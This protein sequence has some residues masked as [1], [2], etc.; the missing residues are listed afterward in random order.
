MTSAEAT[1]LDL[2]TENWAAGV[3]HPSSGVLAGTG[4]RKRRELPGADEYEIDLGRH[5]IPSD[6]VRRT[7]QIAAALQLP[8]DQIA[9]EED[10]SLER[11]VSELATETFTARLVVGRRRLMQEIQTHPG[12]GALAADGPDLRVAIGF[13]M[14]GQ[15]ARWMLRSRRGAVNGSIFGAP[16]AGGTNL[17]L[18]LLAATRSRA[19][20]D[21]CAID[22]GDYAGA[23]REAAQTA[24]SIAEAIDLLADLTSTATAPGNG[25]HHL[26]LID[27]LSRLLASTSRA[28]DLLLR[29]LQVAQSTGI[30]V[31]MRVDSPDLASFGGDRTLRSA[32]WRGNFVA[33]RSAVRWPLIFRD[34]SLPTDPTELPEDLPGV[35]YLRGRNA[36]FRGYQL[37]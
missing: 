9:V 34:P 7:P 32:A 8:V 12:A 35:G 19:E 31:A 28:G 16:C 36:M 2:V 14:D 17:L 37:V 20:I 3:G 5:W 18:G 29:L 1:L 27:N 15:P 21:V 13:H 6:A 22:V 25:R 30:S 10:R 26:L 11:L 24:S 4:L 23:F 33:L